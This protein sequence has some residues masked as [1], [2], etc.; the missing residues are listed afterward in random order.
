MDMSFGD[1]LTHIKSV[2]FGGGGEEGEKKQ[3]KTNGL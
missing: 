2:T 1:D 3:I